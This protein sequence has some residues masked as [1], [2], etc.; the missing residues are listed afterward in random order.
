MRRTETALPELCTAV[1]R[2]RKATKLSQVDLAQSLNCSSQTL[3][4]F[5]CGHRIPRSKVILLKFRELAQALN[6]PPEVAL[7]DEALGSRFL[8]TA[9]ALNFHA[10]PPYSL[11]EWRLMQA[12]RIAVRCWPALAWAI[13]Q[14]AG[15]A[16]AVVDEILAAA[17]PSSVDAAFYRDLEQR[18]NSVAEQRSF[19]AFGLTTKCCQ[20]NAI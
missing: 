7:F 8:E 9:R 10:E 15:E 3:S 17:V 14:A 6:L 16:V 13:E 19:T 11:H 5:E 20:K 2:L 4:N 12:A 18:I 1:R